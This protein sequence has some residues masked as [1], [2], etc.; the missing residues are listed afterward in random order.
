M[1]LLLDQ[2]FVL[3]L[4]ESPWAAATLLARDMVGLTPWNA[5]LQ[6]GE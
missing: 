4:N 1:P 5:N 6:P 2:R 3:Q